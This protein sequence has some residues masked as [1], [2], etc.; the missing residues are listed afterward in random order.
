SILM[1]LYGSLT[2]VSI[3]KLYLGGIIPGILIGI[4]QIITNQIICYARGYTEKDAIFSWKKVLD[5]GY[6][7][8]GDILVPIILI[9]SIAY[10]NM[11]LN[12]S[13]M[14]DVVVTFFIDVL[15]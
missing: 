3:G 7:A 13:V 14:A 5:T 1:V 2:D 8:S 11:T 4:L 6:K 10:V 15:I 12:E 9:G